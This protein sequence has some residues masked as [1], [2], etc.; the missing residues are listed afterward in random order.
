MFPSFEILKTVAAACDVLVED[1]QGRSR[2]KT[3]AQARH[4][5][6]YFLREIN[7]LSYPAIG[8]I[9]GRDHTT[10]IHSY[11]KIRHQIER[12]SNFKEFTEKLFPSF[13]D[14]K[15]VDVTDAKSLT[16]DEIKYLQSILSKSL[17]YKK[18]LPDLETSEDVLNTFKSIEITER[19][20]DILSKYRTGMTL[21]EISLTV[22]LTRERVRQI[23]MNTVL[24]ELGQKARDGFKIDVKEYVNSQKDLHRKSRR[25]SEDQRNE[26]MNKIKSGT[27]IS[28]ILMLY[29]FSEEKF[30][31]FFPQY[32]EKTKLE[33]AN[34]KRWSRSYDKCRKCGTVVVPHLR[35]G[36]CEACL[37]SFRKKRREIII[38]NFEN[39][40]V[41]CGISRVGCFRKYKRDFYLTRKLIGESFAP[42]CRGCF[43]K[44]VGI[45]MANKRWG[46]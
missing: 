9:M 45:N 34:K 26:I 12:E 10:V 23:I 21:E 29:R 39:K 11:E 31:E 17:G 15:R 30:L 33:F 2:R 36:Y 7:G 41:K 24:K 42:L 28:Q 43:L 32:E 20:T 14:R 16:R 38:Q 19:E 18:I 40:C 46:R 44:L 22:N 1:I 6:A 25:L 3:T 8:D 27:K 5:V 37:G 13:D 35:K 4:L